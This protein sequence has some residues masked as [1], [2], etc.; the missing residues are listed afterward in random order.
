[1]RGCTP[2]IEYCKVSHKNRLQMKQLGARY[3]FDKLMKLACERLRFVA[4]RDGGVERRSHF[5]RI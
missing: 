3:V 2:F 1:M 4:C 5:N